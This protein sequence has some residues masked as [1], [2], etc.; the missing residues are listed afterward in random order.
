MYMSVQAVGCA[1]DKHTRPVRYNGRRNGQQRNC[2]Q[3]ASNATAR[4]GHATG[5]SSGQHQNRNARVQ[6]K[7]KHT[8]V[9]EG[10]ITGSARATRSG[11]AEA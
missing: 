6:Q 2:T 3:G 4:R 7:H 1:R 8:R 5:G 10:R 9:T 11:Y